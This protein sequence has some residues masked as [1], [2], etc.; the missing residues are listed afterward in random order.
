M[1]NHSLSARPDS[2]PGSR[3]PYRVIL[4]CAAGSVSGFL[5]GFDT[6]VINGAVDP[7]EK[8]FDLSAADV[9]VVVAVTLFGAAFGAMAAGWAA[10]RMGRPKVMSLTALVFFVS[11]IGCGM[12]TGLWYLVAWRLLTGVGVGF[13]TVIGPLYLSEI[14]PAHLRGRL[15][16]LQQM[17][18]VLGIFTALLSDSFIAYLLDGADAQNFLGLPTWRWMLI[19]RVVPSLLYGVL[20]MRIPESPRYLVARGRP[21]KAAAT[22]VE[23]HQ[24]SA[25]RA[26]NDVRRMAASMSSGHGGH[27]RDL[28]SRKTGLLPIVW[29]GIGLAALQAFVGID[30]IFYYSTSLWKSVGFGESASFGLSVLTSMINVVS[31]VFA[32]LL[33]DRV[34][35]RRLLLVGSVGMAVS[36][37]LVTIGFSTANTKGG[38][39]SLPGA[40]GPLTLIGANTF[41]VFFAVSWGPVVWVLLG[42]MFPNSIRGVALSLA[43]SVN[44]MSGV[45]VN[46]SFPSLRDISL[47]GS[48]SLYAVMAVAS[49]F[50]VHY[51]VRETR[52]RELEDMTSHAGM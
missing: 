47:A 36:L 24:I 9:G 13:A 46:L 6:A 41:V 5:F 25:D 18:I 35:R 52:N 50:L 3:T 23:L 33:I 14:A 31:T 2:P 45:V 20:S 37:V 1:T 11:A 19:A 32:I 29:V 49:W 42:E 30:V 26:E 51:G 12:S 28:L 44:W 10:D 48:Y 39:L 40:W 27:F 15:S 22:L 4:I 7:I 34:G 16:S 38:E 17:S 43:A 8:A 21:E